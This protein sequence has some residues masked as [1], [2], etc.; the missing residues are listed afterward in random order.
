MNIRILMISVVLMSAILKA[1][2]KEIEVWKSIRVV[3]GTR[4]W[5]LKKN[6]EI[7]G[8]LRSKR[9]N[10]A[11][12]WSKVDSEHIFKDVAEKKQQALSLIGIT[13]WTPDNYSWKRGDMYHELAIE[14]TYKNFRFQKI[15]FWEHHL[16]GPKETYTI[17]VVSPSD[18]RPSR[19]V[20]ENFIVRA[21]D[22]IISKATQ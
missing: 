21:K 3:D 22:T 17:L 7:I 9:R 6:P 16:F 4:L 2:D 19:E 1:D 13:H 14:G 20:V 10:R 15:A 11:V 18:Q 5:T 8:T 12:D